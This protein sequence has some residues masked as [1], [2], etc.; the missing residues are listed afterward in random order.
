M[1]YTE[2]HLR[3]YI[4]C[5]VCILLLGNTSAMRFLQLSTI[6]SRATTLRTHIHVNFILKGSLA[7][8]CL[9]ALSCCRFVFLA[10]VCL[11]SFCG[12]FKCGNIFFVMPEKKNSKPSRLIYLLSS[13]DLVRVCKCAFVCVCVPVCLGAL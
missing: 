1:L 8:I 10:H 3:I 7:D 12:T 9:K 4:K 6:L 13:P 2:I 11:F 5:N